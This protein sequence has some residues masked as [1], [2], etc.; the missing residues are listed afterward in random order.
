MKSKYQS[1]WRMGSPTGQ[2]RGA[3]YHGSRSASHP[4]KKRIATVGSEPGQS[5]FR[6]EVHIMS[7]SSVQKIVPHLWY[8]KE[9]VEAARFYVTIFPNSRVNRV[10]A[11]PTESPSG[12][13]GSVDIVEFTLFGQA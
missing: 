7:Q 9:A 8:T 5:S 1:T 3:V 10:T 2:F 4:P 13:A 12:P 11:L 6:P